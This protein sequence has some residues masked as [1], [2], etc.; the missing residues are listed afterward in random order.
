MTQTLLCLGKEVWDYHVGRVVFVFK[1]E[2]ARVAQMNTC[3][4]SLGPASPGR[5]HRVMNSRQFAT[6]FVC[7]AGS[8]QSL[9]QE[10]GESHLP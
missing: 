4:W 10:S 7:E 2:V 8:R 3:T 9:V 6:G 1:V 5:L